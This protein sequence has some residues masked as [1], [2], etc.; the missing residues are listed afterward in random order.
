MSQIDESRLPKTGRPLPD[1][2]AVRTGVRLGDSVDVLKRRGWIIVLSALS[3]GAVVF[4]NEIG[5][6]PT[7]TAEV[8]L[9]QQRNRAPLEAFSGGFGAMVSPEFTAT[10]MEILRTRAVLA[11][12]VDS[13]NLRVKV[14][15]KAAGTE[16][17]FDVVE[18]GRTAPAAD[19]R[20]ELV[21]GRPQLLIDETDDPIGGLEADNW[22]LGPGVR[23]HVA[24]GVDLATSVEQP[25]S[26]VVMLT[27]EAIEDLSESLDIGAVRGTSLI[28]VRFTSPNPVLAA[29]VLNTLTVSFQGYSARRA[30]EEAVRRREFLGQ[31]L[32]DLADS[33]RVEQGRLALYQQ[34]SQTI[35][36]QLQSGTLAAALVEAQTNLRSFQFEQ[37]VLEGLVRSLSKGADGTQA[38]FERMVAL[39]S[40]LIPTGP[41]M[42]ERLQDLKAER[43]RLTASQF[44]LTAMDP[45]VEPIDSLIAATQNEMRAVADQ[46]LGIIGDRVSDAEARVNQL[47]EDV[48]ELPARAAMFARL[49]QRVGAVQNIFNV[50][51]EKY[52]EARITEAVESGDVELIDPAIIPIRSDP[53]HRLRTIVFGFAAGLLVGL[54]LALTLE[55]MDD[56]LRYPEQ[57]AQAAGLAVIGRIPKLSLKNGNV[58]SVFR[59]RGENAGLEEV[60]GAEAFRM[61]RTN[62]RFVQANGA[63]VFCV[64]SPGPGEGKSIVALNLAVAMADQGANVLLVD[65]DMRRPK[66]H[67]FC[68]IP[69]EPGLSD[70]LLN[71]VIPA[72]PLKPTRYD[73]LSLLPCG[74]QVSNPA[75]LLG[76]DTFQKLIAFAR[77][78]FDAIVIDSPPVLIVTDAG[79][80]AQTVDEVLLVAKLDQTHR[81][82]L[83]HAV[84]SF[85]HLDIPMVGIVVNFV[86][87][88]AGYGYG[89]YYG[90][91]RTPAR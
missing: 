40:D 31:Q 10:Q 20:L 26:I 5:R 75:E 83:G 30:R 64:T 84:E 44:G 34:E 71:Q 50:L 85:R 62:L 73:R 48:G 76:S 11:H 3:A 17:L 16:R 4:V 42:Y 9:Q 81:S 18:V 57:A 49:E 22:V 82:A 58:A 12:V 67:E 23:L 32:I 74:I 28:R 61:L 69:M 33:L 2:E 1:R 54:A 47:S 35:D 59:D 41:T 13:L 65:G 25:I 15:S 79:V 19:Y 39:G 51:A 45:A 43:S 53:A 90:E 38:T 70:V 60:E 29:D 21:D 8:L 6:L 36:P 66:L 27:E 89:S 72:K 77:E 87:S 7:Y 14:T 91:T 63:R 68:D 78:S 88:G 46:A 52:Y 37:S 55:Y 80:I 56:S 24:A 86:S